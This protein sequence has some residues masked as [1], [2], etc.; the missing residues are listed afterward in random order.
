MKIDPNMFNEM[1]EAHISDLTATAVNV[2]AQY[3]EPA[4]F[5]NDDGSFDPDVAEEYYS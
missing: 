4:P 5:I 2:T 3:S 1:I